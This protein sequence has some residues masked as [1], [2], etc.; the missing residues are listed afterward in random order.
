M[1]SRDIVHSQGKIFTHKKKREVA[2]WLYNKHVQEKYMA[3]F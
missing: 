2:L 1:F 3:D